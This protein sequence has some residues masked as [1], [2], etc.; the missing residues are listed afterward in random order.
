[1]YIYDLPNKVQNQIVKIR[2][3]FSNFLALG[4]LK[5]T[6]IFYQTNFDRKTVIFRLVE[7]NLRHPLNF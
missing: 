6:K 4:T 5:D 3:W 7:K 2:Q 1:M